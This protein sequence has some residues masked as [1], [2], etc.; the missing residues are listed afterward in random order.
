MNEFCFGFKLLTLIVGF[1]FFYSFL[2]IEG[3][4]RMFIEEK[5]WPTKNEL[6]WLFGAYKP[7]ET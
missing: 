5:I 4:F 6:K 3:N 7:I 2:I 1:A